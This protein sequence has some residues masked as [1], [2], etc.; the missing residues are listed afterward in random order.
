MRTIH[1]RFGVIAGFLILLVLLAI[2][3]AILRHQLAVQ[4]GNQEW[5]SHS[6]RVVQELR[7]TESLVKDAETGQ[8]GYLYTGKL[9]YL[10]PYTLAASQIDSHLQDLNTEIGD[11]PAQQTEAA[12]LR[13]LVHQKL[14]ELAQTIS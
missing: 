6:R 13:I 4:V 1:K 14:D 8:R 12:N 3:A 11:N 2:N 5:F 7:N 9:D 10:G